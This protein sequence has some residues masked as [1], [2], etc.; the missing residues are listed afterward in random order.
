MK[1]TLRRIYGS[2]TSTGQLEPVEMKPE[3]VFVAQPDCEENDE[4]H[5]LWANRW[6]G[7]GRFSGR[8]GIGMP[9]AGAQTRLTVL[10]CNHL[11]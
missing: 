7:R 8:R 9:W 4:S 10:V 11:Q 5:V 2:T 6:R 1:A 3:P